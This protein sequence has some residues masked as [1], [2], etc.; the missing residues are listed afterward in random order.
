M[1]DEVYV[2][3]Y[4]DGENYL[5]TRTPEKEMLKEGFAYD[6]LIISEKGMQVSYDD[7]DEE[8]PITR[9]VILI[10]T[11]VTS[12]KKFLLSKD[13][14]KKD[15]EDPKMMKL[16]PSDERAV[17]LI[18]IY[19]AIKATFMEEAEKAKK[20]YTGFRL[21]K[22]AP[23]EIAQMLPMKQLITADGARKPML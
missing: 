17:R 10:K 22:F 15:D 8:Y 5:L 12:R 11:P 2:W 21:R 6:V 18:E 13:D 16:S 14:T 23:E 9:D 19:D 20:E 7:D 4:G 3:R 1:S